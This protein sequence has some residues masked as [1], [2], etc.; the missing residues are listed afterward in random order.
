MTDEQGAAPKEDESMC[1]ACVCVCGKTV[2]LIM[3]LRRMTQLPCD[4]LHTATMSN[5]ATDDRPG[6]TRLGMK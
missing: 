2:V 3:T 4:L 1:R 6:H 5:H